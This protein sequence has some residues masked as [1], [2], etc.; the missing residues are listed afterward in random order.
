MSIEKN[1]DHEKRAHNVFQKISSCY[2]FMNDIITFRVHRLWKK[3]LIKNIPMESKK[4][5]DVCCGTGDIAIGMGRKLKTAQIKALDFSDSM[6]RVANNRA[7]TKHLKNI[8][9]ILGN[10]LSIPFEENSFDTVTISLGI[11]NTCD[12]KKVLSE[13]NR[14]LKPGGRFFC[15]EASYPDPLLLRKILKFYCRVLV[16]IM[17]KIIVKLQTEYRWLDESVDAFLSKEELT[18]LIKETKFTNV[19][20]KTYLFGS[21]TLHCGIKGG[22]DEH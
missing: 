16:P 1:K 15:M 9:F 3:D 11:R 20:L 8:E 12:Y 4:I 17:G 7:N 10:A 18:A 21:C 22:G 6:L 13:I 19:T 5:L 2:D 14:V